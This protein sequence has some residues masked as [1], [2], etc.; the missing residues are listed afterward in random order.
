MR[1]NSRQVIGVLAATVGLAMVCLNGLRPHAGDSLELAC[2]VCF[3]AHILVLARISPTA[4]PGRLT[5][6]QVLTVGVLSLGWTLRAGDLVVPAG[7]RAWSALVITA[8]VASALAF[9][10]QT[11]A[12][13]TSPPSRIALILTA[14][15]VFAG[16]FGYWLADD[17]ITWAYLFGAVLIIAGILITELQTKGRSCT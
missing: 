4:H 15:P 16:V 7:V 8:V 14:A 12:Q 1:P 2:A 13:E 9:F 3:A 5:F 10:V 17:P 11:R 6:V